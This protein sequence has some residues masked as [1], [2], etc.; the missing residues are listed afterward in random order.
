MDTEKFIDAMEGMTLDNTAIGKL[1]VRACDHH[2]CCPST[3]E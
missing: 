3:T 1:Q 2:S